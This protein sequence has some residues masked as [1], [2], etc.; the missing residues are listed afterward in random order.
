MRKINEK[1][2]ISG[3]SA[4]SFFKAHLPFNGTNHRS[5]YARLVCF[6]LETTPDVVTIK[7]TIVL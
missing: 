3:G 1:T 7:P 5:L 2:A 6:F 4:F